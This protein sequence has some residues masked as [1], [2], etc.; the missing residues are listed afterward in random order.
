MVLTMETKERNCEKKNSHH[1]RINGHGSI[2]GVYAKC[3][4]GQHAWI[5][6]HGPVVVPEDRNHGITSPFEIALLAPPL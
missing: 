5:G 6:P 2:A 3:G 1:S 4:T